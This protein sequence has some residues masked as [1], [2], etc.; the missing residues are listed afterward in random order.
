MTRGKK[1]QNE[2]FVEL[3]TPRRNK[4]GKKGRS[5][6]NSPDDSAPRAG[7]STDPHVV[8]A[9]DQHQDEELLDENALAKAIQL[10][11]KKGRLIDAKTRLEQLR[12]ENARKSEEL[13][14]VRRNSIE[15]VEPDNQLP[16][17]SSS[18]GRKLPTLDEVQPDVRE[19]SR[20]TDDYYG[21]EVPPLSKLRSRPDFQRQVEAQFEAIDPWKHGNQE[22]DSGTGKLVS[23]RVAKPGTGVKR[24][25]VWPHTTVTSISGSSVTYDRLDLP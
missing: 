13:I 25:V 21:E 22:A 16:R 2:E 11:E 1:K 14:N 20:T 15:L 6:A 23:G 19:P 7:T 4:G 17:L 3:K 8:E 24:Q 5:A 18:L 10:E 9:R 12:L